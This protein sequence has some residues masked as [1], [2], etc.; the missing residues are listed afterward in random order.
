MPH[1]KWSVHF[2]QLNKLKEYFIKE[3]LKNQFLYCSRVRKFVFVEI[4]IISTSGYGMIRQ[5]L[6]K[7]SVPVTR[8]V[9]LHN[10]L[11]VPENRLQHLY[12]PWCQDSWSREHIHLSANLGVGL[13]SGLI[14]SPYFLPIQLKSGIISF[15]RGPYKWAL[16]W[17]R[18]KK[19]K[20]IYFT[21]FLLI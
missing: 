15:I 9:I 4:L 7:L 2:N 12:V 11:G 10:T 3:L 13:V 5:A 6:A 19:N 14:W 1:T 8:L 20:I 16:E 21:T 18:V 17:G